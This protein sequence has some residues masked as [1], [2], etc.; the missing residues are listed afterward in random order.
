MNDADFR[1]GALQALEQGGIKWG[2]HAGE[3][4][5]GYFVTPPTSP[6]WAGPDLDAAVELLGR[7]LAEK[8]AKEASQCTTHKSA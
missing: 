6:I 1:R 8:E 7:L 3:D 5:Y 2:H 4:R